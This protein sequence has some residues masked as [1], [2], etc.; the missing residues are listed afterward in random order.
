VMLRL[1]QHNA[2]WFGD[3]RSCHVLRFRSAS[4]R[5]RSAP[6]SLLN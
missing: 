1:L 2:T 3:F 4:H 6:R 5:L